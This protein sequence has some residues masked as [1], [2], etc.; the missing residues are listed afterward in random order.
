MALRAGEPR[1]SFRPAGAALEQIS[2]VASVARGLLA[3]MG[4]VYDEH[5]IATLLPYGTRIATPGT[6]ALDEDGASIAA[7]GGPPTAG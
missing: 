3:R 7:V 1:A 6:N 2:F 5:G 4:A